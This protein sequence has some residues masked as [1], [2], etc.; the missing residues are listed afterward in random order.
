MRSLIICVESIWRPL[1]SRPGIY[2]AFYA[3]KT[4]FKTA[5]LRTIET[6]FQVENEGINCSTPLIHKQNRAINLSVV[7]QLA[8]IAFDVT[9][10]IQFA[11]QK[12]KKNNFK[13]K[14]REF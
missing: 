14:D 6:I 9:K 10:W 2:E 7:Q 4:A 13:P 5:K 12:S 11:D 8:I 3:L 1:V